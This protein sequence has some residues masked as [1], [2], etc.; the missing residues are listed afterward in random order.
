MR[1]VILTILLCV[2]VQTKSQ[3]M[4]NEILA[5]NLT[6]LADPDYQDFGDWIELYNEGTSSLDLSGY[7]LSDDMA[8]PKR[9]VFPDATV[10]P[11]H[12]FLIIWCDN[13]NDG[14][15]TN[16][17]L[18]KSGEL[19][20]L[21]NPGGQMIDQVEFQQQSEDISYGR[22]TDGS[23]NWVFFQNPSPGTSNSGST[24]IVAALPDY[25]L[26]S[27]FYE[28]TQ[29]LEISKQSVQAKVYYTI[30]GSIPTPN[31]AEY[32][33]PLSFS[34]T[35]VVRALQ[36]QSGYATSGI[37]NL[38]IF[39][40]E[41]TT[42]PVFSLITDPDNL[43]DEET[44]IY[45]KGKDYVWGWGNGNFWQDWERP[46]FIQF[47]EAD[48]KQKIE[49]G[50]G[51]KIAG[52]LTRTASQKSLRF[53][54]R[55]EYGKKKFSYRFFE[56]KEISSFN[57]IVLRSSGNDWA[58]TM[59]ADGLMASLV[60][61]QMDIDYNAYR[62]AI[63]FI[64]G[65]YWGIH[66]IREK[67]GDDYLEENHRVDKDNIDLISQQHDVREGDF[68]AYSELITFVRGHDMSIEE[69]YSFAKERMQIGEYISYYLT[70]VFYANHDWPAGN[71]KYW[72]PRRDEGK[73]RW[74]LFDTDLAFTDFW[75]N[76]VEWVTDPDPYYE[77]STDLFRGLMENAEFRNEFLSKMEYHLA[78]TFSTERILHVIDSLQAN[79]APEMPRHIERWYGHHGW[80]FTTS[81]GVYLETPWLESYESWSG[82]L[83]RFINFANERQDYMTSFLADYYDLGSPIRL[84][85]E[86]EPAGYGKIQFGKEWSIQ[87][88]TIVDLLSD[89]S[90]SIR[91]VENYSSSFTKWTYLPDTPSGDT[92]NLVYPD[93]I[94]MYYDTGV[95]PGSAWK[96]AD[97]DDSNWPEGCATLG[98]N[99]PS[100]CTEISFGGDSGNKFITYLFRLH[101]QL[102][103][104]DHWDELIVDLV[105]DDG[106]L[107][108]L[109]GHEI[110]SSNM[111]ENVSFNT[112]ALEGVNAEDETRYYSYIISSEYLFSGENVLAVEVHQVS[113]ESSDLTFNL[114][115]RGIE[116]EG[117][118]EPEVYFG[119]QFP[120]SRFSGDGALTA[121]FEARS[122]LPVLSINEVMPVNRGSFM[123][124][125][126]YFRDWLEIYN[127]GSE[128]ID[129]G[130]L[131][132]TDD[133]TKPEKWKIPTS[134]S[135]ETTV[136]AYAYKLIWVDNQPVLGPVHADFSLSGSGEDLGLSYFKDGE[137]SWID[138]LTY[139]DVQADES[140]GRYPDGTDNW[141][142]FSENST[143]GSTNTAGGGSDLI[144]G[145]FINEFMA[146]NTSAYLNESGMYDDWIELYNSNDHVIN[147]AG[148]Y[149]TDRSDSPDSWL[150]P[151]DNTEVTAIPPRGFLLVIPSARPELG[152]LHTNFQLAGGGEFVGLSQ[153]KDGLFHYLDSL[154]YPS[155]SANISFGRK[156][157]G[158]SEWIYFDP[159][160]PKQSNNGSDGVETGGMSKEN[161]V[162]Y[163]NPA[164]NHLFVRMEGYFP[165][166]WEMRVYSVRGV[167]QRISNRSV[168]FISPQS[169]CIS[170]QIGHLEKGIY[171]LVFVSGKQQIT[172]TVLKL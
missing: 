117:D 26:E 20:M 97:F 79:I 1:F 73:F 121:H 95:D 3:I 99:D 31:S 170:I 70:Q 6:V 108:Y 43:F 49:Q 161:V 57:E 11:S 9:W 55:S 150:I 75:K 17:R 21:S 28:E 100:I 131:F 82:F 115:L 64:N 61:R 33:T 172:K 8:E 139:P 134:N 135:S 94:W 141:T 30:D 42:L 32:L 52:A 98:Y 37:S 164:S 119:K 154:T 120:L 86:L 12:S 87:S 63:L 157:D 102:A 13:K 103:N 166:Y 130:G 114:G 93:D 35:T 142:V 159:S 165:S 51:M 14:L 40:N 16:F 41:A 158:A 38:T 125:D 132:L 59:L 104:A 127:P 146:R 65:Q 143:P 4:I 66:N 68:S 147:I 60:S 171:F 140:F 151:S 76:S 24:D 169:N 152:A 22:Q 50:A 91:A 156:T 78:T 167:Q 153:K 53:I 45:V 160:T 48:R 7:Y 29:T 138:T 163:P 113:S 10:I 118:S 96:N 137:Y 116:I 39:I 71:I 122:E 128:A 133:F 144:T 2:A 58:K 83:Q 74:I 105:R 126:G 145:L 109:N 110:V 90:V 25:S 92:M 56:D 62:P 44:G 112:L 19:V 89:Q 155:Q 106:A 72:R 85:L 107:V 88:N 67:V 123:D 46:C 80:T 5:D 36:T 136:N 148:L 15:H 84:S 101:F 168:Y 47:W 23:E 34:Q 81:G 18:G 77:G 54:A 111:P 69:N 149:L 129:L 162:V 27:G 124:S